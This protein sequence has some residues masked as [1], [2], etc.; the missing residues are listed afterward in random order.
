MAPVTEI[1]PSPIAG[2]WYEA[3]AGQLRRQMEK[4]LSQAE[5]PA[6][7]GE[8]IAVIAPHAGYRYSG[9]TAGYAFRSVQGQQPDLVVVVSPLH[10]YLA[11]AWFTTSHQAYATPLGNIKVDQV[12]LQEVNRLL[13][14]AG[15]PELLAIANDDEHSIEI[16]L[17]FLQVALAGN[18]NLLPIMVRP[19]P[20]EMLYKL[21]C[22]I[23]S[24]VRSRRALLV[25]STDLSH[26]YPEKTARKLDSEMLHQISEFSPQGVLDA[27]E[28]GAGFACGAPAVAAI[29]WAAR[30]L[31]GD[32]VQVLHQSTSASATGDES[33]VVGYGAAV[34]YKQ[35]R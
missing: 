11:H 32:R 31:G 23:A 16:E 25:A 12:A 15:T 19:L 21:G 8:V 6:I 28:K 2:L 17:P 20:G 14:E 13:V 29:L 4:Y 22:A 3:D 1:R 18:F 26:F 27:E 10:S 35:S 33:R 9:H 30:E 5:A 34:V 7:N 24:A